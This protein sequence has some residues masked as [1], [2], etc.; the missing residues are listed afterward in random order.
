VR[1]TKT[2]NFLISITTPLLLQDKDIFC[3]F[4]CFLIGQGLFML[5]QATCR[6]SNRHSAGK[7]VSRTTFQNGSL[8]L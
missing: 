2:T 1:N 5:L 4:Y 6:T 3:L 7:I 8:T